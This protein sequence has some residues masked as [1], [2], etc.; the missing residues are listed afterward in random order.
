MIVWI[1]L[2]I[3][4]FIFKFEPSY[5]HKILPRQQPPQCDDICNAAGGIGT[6]GIANENT[7]TNEHV[8]TWAAC[9]DS[10]AKTLSGTHKA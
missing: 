7:C 3:V 6:A 2:L 4:S 5:G 1:T 9:L 10:P 8:Q